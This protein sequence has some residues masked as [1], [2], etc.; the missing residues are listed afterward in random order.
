VPE[1]RVTDNAALSPDGDDAVRLPQPP[2]DRAA[3]RADLQTEYYKLVDIVSAFDQ[4][5][6]TI[7]SWGVTL[8]LASLGLGFQQDHYGLFLVAA[9]SGL[10]FWLL[11]AVTKSHQMRYYPRMGD[12]EVAAYELFGVE[13]PTGPVSSP[14][15][16]YSWWVASSRVRGGDPGGPLHTPRRGPASGRR[17]RHPWFGPAVMLP[18]VVAVVLGGVLFALGL[19]GVFGPI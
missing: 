17:G 10:A 19:F 2:G 9:V 5:L 13:S 11:E 1:G 4:R 6:V 14:L 3:L 8:S 7:K 12:I 16:D 18:H 15:I